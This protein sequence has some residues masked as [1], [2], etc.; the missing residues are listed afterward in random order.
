MI[1]NPKQYPSLCLAY[2]VFGSCRMEVQ[3]APRCSTDAA[4]AGNTRHT[5][6]C[7]VLLRFSNCRCRNPGRGFGCSARPCKA[8]RIQPVAATRHYLAMPLGWL[9][10]RCGR[11][12]G[13]PASTNFQSAAAESTPLH[14]RWYRRVVF[15]LSSSSKSLRNAYCTCPRNCLQQMV[16]QSS[17]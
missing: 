17:W 14:A 2:T 4:A 9:C 8:C 11:C 3:P 5:A 1:V 6:I 10:C 15:A 12:E 16:K 13:E 7:P